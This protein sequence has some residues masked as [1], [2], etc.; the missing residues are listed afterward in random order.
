M[1]YWYT[2]W[3]EKGPPY[4]RNV[5]HQLA[6]RPANSA[7]GHGVE[8][9]PYR[10]VENVPCQFHS[11]SISICGRRLPPN[12]ETK[13]KNKTRESCSKRNGESRSK[14]EK[15]LEYEY[16]LVKT[17]LNLNNSY[18][19]IFQTSPRRKPGATLVNCTSLRQHQDQG[20][21]PLPAEDQHSRLARQT[22][23]VETANKYCFIVKCKSHRD[24]YVNVTSVVSKT[25][26]NDWHAQG[27]ARPVVSESVS[28]MR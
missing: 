8:H 25:W 4:A 6:Q 10:Q 28:L 23:C 11:N 18:H 12:V 21:V 1:H 14:R 20:H 27:T 5:G 13:N 19:L 26:E 2:S 22:S 16:F 15:T 3:K 17:W 7:R 9:D 24:F